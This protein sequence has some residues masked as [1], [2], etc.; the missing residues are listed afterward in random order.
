[1]ADFMC[2]R[3]V[4]FM[5]CEW[6]DLVELTKYDHFCEHCWAGFASVARTHLPVT[7]PA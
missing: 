3:D 1:M 5:L 4:D 2:R 7:R 6:L